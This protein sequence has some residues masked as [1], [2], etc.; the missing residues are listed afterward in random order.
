MMAN[1][2]CQA[3]GDPEPKYSWLRNG[4]EI[5]LSDPIFS[6][7]N[8]STLTV[9]EVALIDYGNIRCVASNKL[10]RV[11]SRAVQLVSYSKC[12]DVLHC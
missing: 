12:I 3:R 9:V 10:G 8:T 11:V 4:E 5:P 7:A 6:G 2:T 1:F